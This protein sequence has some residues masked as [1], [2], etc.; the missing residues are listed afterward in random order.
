MQR[1]AAIL[2][3]AATLICAAGCQEP[4][5]EEDL[6]DPGA[7][8][9]YMEPDYFATD[10]AASTSEDGYTTFPSATP[11]TAE[12]TFASSGLHVVAKGDTL[13]RLARQYYND[14]RRW[15]DIY[16]ANRGSLANPD[17][18]YVGQELVIP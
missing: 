18:I 6:Q 14:E 3:L 17:V 11:L 16:E 4:Q 5:Q 13:Y 10:P 1:N 7:Q 9:A 12:S 2:L 8:T 15:K